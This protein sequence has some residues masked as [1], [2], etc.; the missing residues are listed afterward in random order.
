[1]PQNIIPYSTDT[2]ISVFTGS[3]S[4][5]V[6]YEHNDD[7][8][9]TNYLSKVKFPVLAGTSYYIEWDSYS[10]DSGFVF[11]FNFIPVSCLKVYNVNAPT[12]LTDT[13]ATLHWEA[14]L[15]TSQSYDIEYGAV[16]FIQGN[17][18]VVNS[19]TNLIV[20]TGLVSGTIYDYYIRSHCDATTFSDWSS[21]NKLTVAKTC[22]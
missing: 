12:N 6:C 8:S 1:M 21:I 16:G 10:D 11:D 2:R 17:G 22:P 9:T 20:L 7:I 18:T 14:S 19:T 3:C 5:L 13:T 4:N 15:N